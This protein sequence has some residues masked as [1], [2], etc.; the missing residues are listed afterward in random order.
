MSP[1]EWLWFTVCQ[2]LGAMNSISVDSLKVRIPIEKVELLDSTMFSDKI[3][4]DAE[5][6]EVEKEFKQ[7]RFTHQYDGI[8]TS[9]GLE[10]QVTANQKVKTYLVLLFN[11]KLL[12][13]NYFD[14]ITMQNIE[15]VYYRIMA[16]KKVSFSYLDFLS[17]ES[18]DV[19]FKMDTVNQ[20]FERS[21][22]HIHTHAKASKKIGVGCNAFTQPTNLGIEFGKRESATPASPFLK[23]YHKGLELLNGSSFFYRKYIKGGQDVTDLVRLETTIKNKKHF[24]K[25]DIADTTL[26][27]VLSLSQDK[28]ESII[29]DVLKIHLEPRLT[30][31]K[32]P[33]DMKPQ[34]TVYFNAITLLMGQDRPYNLVRE[35]L[36]QS[37]NK[38]QRYKTRKRLDSIYEHAIRGNDADTVT[39]K[40][41]RFFDSIGW[42]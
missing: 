23:L 34:D 33:S 18:T 13:S 32:T 17:A 21:V 14:G 12:H 3:L 42:A 22:K 11:S 29:R 20:N 30:P 38:D 2:M 25:Y 19:D 16:M 28:L 41:S 31:I 40:Q 10:N 36:T 9:F 39:Q 24:R 1:T 7:K 26:K 15:T 35:M 37:M 5:T 27:N 6:H 4:M 8:T